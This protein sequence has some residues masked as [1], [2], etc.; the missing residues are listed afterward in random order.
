MDFFQTRK[1]NKKPGNTGNVSWY[2]LQEIIKNEESTLGQR[3]V[4]K[5]REKYAI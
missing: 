4:E 5:V 1:K 3:E 2:Y